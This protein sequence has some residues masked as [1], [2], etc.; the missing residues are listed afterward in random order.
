MSKRPY[1][2]LIWPQRIEWGRA[3]EGLSPRPGTKTAFLDEV[4]RDSEKGS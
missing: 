3:E 4:R 2:C 1:S